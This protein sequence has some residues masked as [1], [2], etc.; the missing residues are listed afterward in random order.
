M[1]VSILPMLIS[2]LG[3]TLSG[4]P[5]GTRCSFVRRT[6]SSIIATRPICMPSL[7]W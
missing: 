1:A 4:L 6:R 3:S 2:S 5:A 7:G